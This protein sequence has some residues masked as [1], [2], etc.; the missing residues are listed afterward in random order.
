VLGRFHTLDPKA[1]NYS[2]QS[3][4]VYAGNDP[5]KFIDKN[6]ENP[7][8]PIV[9]GLTALDLALISTGAVASGVILHKAQN[10]SIELNP[11]IS[12]SLKRN[13]P[14]LENQRK[15]DRDSQRETENIKMQHAKDVKKNIGEPTSDGGNSPRGAGN[16]KLVDFVVGTGLVGAAVKA[17]SD[18]AKPADSNSTSVDADRL[19]L[20]CVNSCCAH[21]SVLKASA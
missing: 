16:N 7:A 18:I 21:L 20:H 14:G 8:I 19:G 3:P 10:G 2:F 1:E 4:Y 17:I 11:N 5:V 13:N 15:R 9:A 6:G 12:L